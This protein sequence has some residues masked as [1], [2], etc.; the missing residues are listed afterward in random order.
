VQVSIVQPLQVLNCSS[1]YKSVKQS[2]H[3]LGDEV[4][5]ELDEPVGDRRQHDCDA[6]G[7]S[8]PLGEL[9]AAGLDKSISLRVDDRSKRAGEEGR[10][11]RSAIMVAT[12]TGMR[13]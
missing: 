13:K 1:W 4:R 6:T 2:P 11:V 5:W 9:K 7:Q 8:V 12:N 10:D 3:S